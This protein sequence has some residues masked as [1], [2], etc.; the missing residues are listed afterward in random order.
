MLPRTIRVFPFCR[1]IV[2]SPFL[3]ISFRVISVS[4]PQTAKA[5]AFSSLL[6]NRY[7]IIPCGIQIIPHGIVDHE[8]AVLLFNFKP[9]RMLLLPFQVLLCQALPDAVALQKTPEDPVLSFL[10]RLYGLFQCLV[11]PYIR[12]SF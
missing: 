10:S 5:A 1:R 3:L 4:A 6:Y 7:I 2:G 12:F 9:E 8:L 11:C